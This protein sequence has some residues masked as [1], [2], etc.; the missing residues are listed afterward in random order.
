MQDVAVVLGD[1]LFQ[2][3]HEEVK[4]KEV[5]DSMLG[6][7]PTDAFPLEVLSLHYIQRSKSFAGI[8]EAYLVSC[9]LHLVLG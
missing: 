3:Q 8:A 4:M 5:C 6:L 7:Y 1:F 9:G 2:L